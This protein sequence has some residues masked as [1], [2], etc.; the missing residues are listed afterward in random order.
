MHFYLLLLIISHDVLFWFI[1]FRMWY[2]CNKAFKSKFNSV[3]VLNDTSLFKL[4]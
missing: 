2:T 1:I 3:L 4:F